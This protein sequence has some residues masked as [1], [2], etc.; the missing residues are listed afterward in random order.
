M[1][2]CKESTVNFAVIGLGLCRCDDVTKAFSDID[3]DE[4]ELRRKIATAFRVL[5]IHTSGWVQAPK[6]ERRNNLFQ[7]AKSIW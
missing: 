5:E 7:S 3:E 1:I 4:E 2:T 6:R